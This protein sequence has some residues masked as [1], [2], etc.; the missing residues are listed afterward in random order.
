MKYIP[1]IV[2]FLYNSTIV[3]TEMVQISHFIAALS[4]S[5][6]L[7]KHNDT[8]TTVEHHCVSVELTSDPW[9]LAHPEHTLEEAG[10]ERIIHVESKYGHYYYL[11]TS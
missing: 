10:I 9:L 5:Q 7:E 4:S 8:N 6:L 2:L 3:E 11:C 1:L